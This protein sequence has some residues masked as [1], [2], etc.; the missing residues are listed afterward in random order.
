LRMTEWGVLWLASISA[1]GPCD[2]SN[3]NSPY[4]LDLNR[5]EKTRHSDNIEFS[6]NLHIGLTGNLI[7]RANYWCHSQ[8]SAAPD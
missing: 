2:L 6:D 1:A 7:E 8:I 5:S 4:P 3:I